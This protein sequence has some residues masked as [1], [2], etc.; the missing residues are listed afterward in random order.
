MRTF[1]RYTNVDG[2]DM[3]AK[4]DAK[5]YTTLIGICILQMC[6]C[7]IVTRTVAACVNLQLLCARV[8]LLVQP[9]VFEAIPIYMCGGGVGAVLI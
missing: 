3:R 2:L 1:E 5:P 8:I 9:R 7:D 4:K 6:M